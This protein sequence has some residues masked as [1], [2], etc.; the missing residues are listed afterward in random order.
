MA[1]VFLGPSSDHLGFGGNVL[2]FR[3]RGSGSCAVCPAPGTESAVPPGS[4]GCFRGTVCHTPAREHAVPDAAETS[5]PLFPS[6]HRAAPDD[7]ALRES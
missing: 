3:T 6:Q 1:P 2:P 5:L 7:G 4:P